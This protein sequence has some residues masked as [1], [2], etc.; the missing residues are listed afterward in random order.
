MAGDFLLTG[1][2]VPGAVRHPR[3]SA[4][5]DRSGRLS[6]LLCIRY[7]GFGWSGNSSPRF[8]WSPRSRFPAVWPAPPGQPRRTLSIPAPEHRW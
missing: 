6:R 5:T 7:V 1:R 4:E 3:R 8:V 2:P